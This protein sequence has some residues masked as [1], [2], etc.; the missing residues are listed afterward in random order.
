MQAFAVRP[1]RGADGPQ[2][3]DVAA[4][5]L[6][7]AARSPSVRR[8]GAALRAGY[9]D[10]RRAGEAVVAER[11]GRF[12][13]VGSY[14]VGPRHPH[15]GRVAIDVVP[16]ERRRGIGSALL[17]ELRRRTGSPPLAAHAF[18]SLPDTVGFYRSR[19]FEIAERA[20]EGTVDPALPAT[21]AWVHA[22]LED[23]PHNAD[24]VPAGDAAP[25]DLIARLLDEV[26]RRTHPWSPP[27]TLP[28]EG[29]RAV[30]RA[31]SIPGTTFAALEG[32][33]LAGAATLIESPMGDAGSPGYLC[34]AGCAD[35][36]RTDVL[37]A[38]VAACLDAAGRQGRTVDVEVS[39]L[40]RPL[41]DCVT[42][43]PGADLFA[44]LV[45]MV[46]S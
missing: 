22:R 37:G 21:A 42:S 38:L 34:W 45:T 6:A 23:A 14:R 12:L 11:E 32:G 29:A 25:H 35:D 9:V 16:Q 17:A 18:V 46:D 40:N 26:Y 10:N 7:G 39:D 44:D 41:W 24:V 19:G 43:I 15:R 3:R 33:H 2:A 27:T 1:A 28:D 8:W 30:Y 5:V 20:L 13:G 4:E 31:A 36:R